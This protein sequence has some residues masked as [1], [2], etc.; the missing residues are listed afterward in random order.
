MPTRSSNSAARFSAALR[1]MSKC[2]S[3]DSLIWRPIVRTGFRDVIGSWK[4]IEI[5]RPRMRRRARSF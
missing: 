4:I 1:F 3:S 5:S 2:V